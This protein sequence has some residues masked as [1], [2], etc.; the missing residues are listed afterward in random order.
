MSISSPNYP[1]N[2]IYTTSL[3]TVLRAVASTVTAVPPY[4]K[5]AKNRS[6]TSSGASSAR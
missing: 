4:S 3:K 6:S 2:G 1:E 5:N